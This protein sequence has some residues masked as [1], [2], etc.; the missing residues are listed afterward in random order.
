MSE[1][2][3]D[4]FEFIVVEKDLLA[5]EI[6]TP[7]K[8]YMKKIYNRSSAFREFMTLNSDQYSGALRQQFAEM[9]KDQWE[10]S[11]S[12]HLVITE[13]DFSSVDSIYQSCFLEASVPTEIQRSWWKAFP[14]GMRSLNQGSEIIGGLSCWPLS[15]TTYDNLV[16]GKIKERDIKVEDMELTN[17]RFFYFSEIA[18]L[19]N[20]R[21][22]KHSYDLILSLLEFLRRYNESNEL[23][24]LALGFSSQ[25]ERLLKKMGFEQVHSKEEMPD[26]QPLFLLSLRHSDYIDEIIQRL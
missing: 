15:E 17:P 10:H 22:A 16:E 4:F 12:V 20:Y 13:N 14:H 24:I 3:A 23:K 18:I 19:N 25:G 9:S 6:R 21:N 7:W 2:L 8:V 11:T 26:H 5:P 1:M